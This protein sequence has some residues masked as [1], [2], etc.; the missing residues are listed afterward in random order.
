MTNKIKNTLPP[1]E[2]LSN[3]RLL[4]MDVDGVLTDGSI[5]YTSAGE[6]VKTFNVKDGAG[7]K[8]WTRAGHA[9]G[10]IT[11]RS[12]VMVERRASEL[13]IR[14]LE[15]G[16]KAK[17]PAFEKVLAAAGA[18]PEQT[19]MIGDDL[20]D[21]PLLRRVGFG[22]AVADAV[23]DLKDAAHFVTEAKGGKGA[24]R[25]VVELVLK[26]QGRWDTIM[27]RYLV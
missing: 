10:I 26:A 22:V 12:S 18:T 25:E 9:A 13:G 5:I 1:P 2:I 16:Q 21:L 17:L 27:E 3:L 8:Y 19:I 6:E 11:G 14:H 23:G 24:V 7:V 15:M 20:M 4:L